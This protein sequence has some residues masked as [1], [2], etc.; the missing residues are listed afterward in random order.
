MTTKYILLSVAALTIWSCN[1]K[2]NNQNITKSTTAG[3]PAFI[4]HTDTFKGAL[5]VEFWEKDCGSL[6]IDTFFSVPSNVFVAYVTKDSMIVTDNIGHITF[7]YEIP[8]SSGSG[9]GYYSG[10]DLIHLLR[11]D[12]GRYAYGNVYLRITN[13]SLLY[14]F[15]ASPSSILFRGGHQS[16][17]ISIFHGRK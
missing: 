8:Y 16:K 3:V 1:K 13:D 9:T 2:D 15:G 14:E 17:S 6:D 12:R 11:I 7:N 10:L 4:P 5:D